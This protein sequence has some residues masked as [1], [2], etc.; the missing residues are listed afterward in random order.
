MDNMENR[1][2]EEVT[3]ESAPERQEQKSAFSTA[4]KCIALI[5]G[6]FALG[7]VIGS[8]TN[9]RRVDNFQTHYNTTTTASAE[10]SA[11]ESTTAE[12]TTQAEQTTE[13]T[14]ETTEKVTTTTTLPATTEDVTPDTKE[15]LVALFNKS[16]NNIKKKATK[17]TRNYDNK[18]HN[19]KLSNYPRVLNIVATPLINSYLI[20]NDIPVEYT[21]ED[22]IRANYPVK[23][24][25]WVSKLTAEDIAEA[26]CVEKKDR[27]EIQLKLL[28]CKDPEE[29]KGVC[30]VMDAVTL[31]I[32]QEY[33]DVVKNCSVEYYDCEINCTIEKD[34][35]NMIYARYTQPMILNITTQALTERKGVFAMTFES[36]YVIEY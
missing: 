2:I 3:A 20:D 30:S 35:G 19:E 16:A 31:E 10:L 32:I 24:R 8:L 18:Q 9:I 15:E 22:I 4:V 12:T 7:N 36:E 17:I 14:T 29:N 11:T 5:I 1:S 25:D 21:D 13:T 27:Y 34:S 23:G 6:L 26:N 33:A 28:Y